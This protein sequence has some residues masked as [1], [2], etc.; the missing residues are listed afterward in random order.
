MLI[1]GKTCT[2]CKNYESDETK[3][4]SRM[5][6]GKMSILSKHLTCIELL[7]AKGKEKTK[8]KIKLRLEQA[9]IETKKRKAKKLIEQV[10]F[11]KV[12]PKC[13]EKKPMDQYYKTTKATSY[14]K[15]C[16]RT[17]VRKAIESNPAAT[18]EYQKKYHAVWS[19]NNRENRKVYM[20]EWNKSRREANLK[21]QTT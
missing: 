5:T 12:C 4:G 15:K 2:V 1:I 19:E 10:L 14:C 7:K 13:E 20:K 17:I 6:K 11:G 18:A 16:H 8:S 21:L 9:K 3:L